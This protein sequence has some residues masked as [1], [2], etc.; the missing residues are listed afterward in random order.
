MGLAINAK[1][2]VEA[3]TRRLRAAAVTHP[4]AAATGGSS[5]IFELAHGG[6]GQVDCWHGRD[7]EGR[8]DHRLGLALSRLPSPDD[9]SVL[10]GT[11]DEPILILQ[12]TG[13]QR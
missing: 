12:A 11:F 8:P 13:V 5:P 1:R 2:Q 9:F 6:A 10:V 3:I 7:L 4:P